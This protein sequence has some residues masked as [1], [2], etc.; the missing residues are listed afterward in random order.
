MKKFFIATISKRFAMLLVGLFSGCLILATAPN[1]TATSFPPGIYANRVTDAVLK[2]STV[3]GVLLSIRWRNIETSKGKYNWDALDRKINA[4]SKAGKK[5]V[6]NA[7]TCGV[8][9]PDWIISDPEV[10]TFEFLDVMKYHSTYNKAFKIP[11][12]WDEKYLSEKQ[13]F[14]DNLGE[15]YANNPAVVGVMVSFVGTFTNDWYIPRDKYKKGDGLAKKELLDKGYS[16]DKMLEVGKRTIDMWAKAFPKQA[17]KLPLG[18]SIPDRNNT[19]T[20]LAERIMNYAYLKYPNRFYAQIN[21]LSTIIPKANNPKVQNASPDRIYYF[22]KLLSQHPEHMGFQ[23][24]SSVSK[25]PRIVDNAGICQVGDYKCI[26]QK[27]MEIALTYKPYFI[28]FWYEDIENPELQDILSNVSYILNDVGNSNVIDLTKRP[29]VVRDVKIKYFGVGYSVKGYA[30]LC[31]QMDVGLVRIPSVAWGAI[32]PYPPKNGRHRYNWQRLD[33]MIREYQNNGFKVQLIVKSANPWACRS[34]ATGSEKFRLSSPPKDQYW[35]D[36]YYFIYNLVERYD[37]DGK[38]DMPGLKTPVLEYEIESEAHNT[39]FFWNGT[40]KEY[41]RLL[42]TAYEAAKKA[43]PN[44]KIVLS[45]I[46]FGDY[47]KKIQQFFEKHKDADFRD[48]LKLAQKCSHSVQKKMRFIFETLKYGN[49]YDEIDL[50]FNRGYKEIPSEIRLIKIILDA[51]SIHNKDIIAGDVCSCPWVVNIPQDPEEER[52]FRIEQASLSSKKLIISAAHGVEGFVLESIRDFPTTYRH[53]L[54]ESFRLAGIFGEEKEPR[55]VFYA[56]KQTIEKIK[57]AT[58][59]ECWEGEGVY[60]YRF[61]FH[62]K[63]PIYV[64]WSETGMKKVKLSVSSGKV[65]IEKLALNKNTEHKT[66][67]ASD[68]AVV[69]EIDDKPLFLEETGESSE[70]VKIDSASLQLEAFV[71]LRGIITHY[72]AK[73]VFKL[74]VNV[75]NQNAI[76]SHIRQKPT[77]YIVLNPKPFPIA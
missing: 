15:R 28:E 57:D 59:A 49:Y 24:I 4:V 43:N 68:R 25:Y 33:E 66:A 13:K 70:S 18:K 52:L 20:S 38:D 69:V 9:V 37:G 23:M 55:P 67:K 27:T 56:Y 65:K 46:N 21:A 48:V 47:G 41:K 51:Y 7:M 1:H 31:K 29:S 12:Y 2:N 58:K 44:A 74:R 32:E 3:E 72:E 19:M 61:Y 50:H 40:V 42:K 77:S 64:V 75:T 17:L 10:E 39:G 76:K 60:A 11:V 22:F 30:F 14:I 34:F 8:S 63:S 45:G 35:D 62:G 54:K 73:R 5:V 53:A 71:F 16:T 6:L 26:I 36:Y